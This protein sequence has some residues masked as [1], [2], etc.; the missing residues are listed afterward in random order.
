M[1]KGQSPRRKRTRQRKPRAKRPERKAK[2]LPK[3]RPGQKTS[4]RAS[5]RERKAAPKN[6]GIPKRNE[7]RKA[8]LSLRPKRSPT[9]RVAPDREIP[10]RTAK[11]WASPI[12]KDFPGVSGFPRLRPKNV[13]RKR[14]PAVTKRK[15]EESR[16]E[17]KISSSLPRKSTAKRKSGDNANS[18]KPMY[19]RGSFPEGNKALPSQRRSFLN[20]TR[21]AKRV[22]K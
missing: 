10:G 14:R 15:A 1:P 12:R 8:S 4:P 17:E 18:K 16:T 22:P 2:E 5:R 13:E 3:A 9:V 6:V 21:R 11:A 19:R 7:K 20:Q